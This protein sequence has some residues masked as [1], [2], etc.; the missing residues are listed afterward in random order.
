MISILARFT[1]PASGQPVAGVP[2]ESP[3]RTNIIMEVTN[4][5]GVSHCADIAVSIP[6][7]Q[8][9]S[10]APERR[11]AFPQRYPAITHVAV[12]AA[13]LT[14][15]AVVP[16]LLSKR[17]I[18]S[19]S[20]RLDSVS[21]TTAALRRELESSAAQRRKDELSPTTTDLRKKVESLTAEWAGKKELSATIAALRKELETSATESA[22]QKEELSVAAAALRRN[23]ETAAIESAKRK[24]ELD[25]TSASLE[26]AR[27]EV[28]RLHRSIEHLRAEYEAFGIT[29]ENMQ[30]FLELTRQAHT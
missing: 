27:N 16:Y 4:Q 15:L 21:V 24:E 22:K 2:T 19:L 26:A 13:L 14:P 29:T 30:Q 6:S 20:R 7:P 18:S 23:L 12:L 10:G 11:T 9:A 28:T 3:V 25:Y 1:A 17:R 8:T 5:P